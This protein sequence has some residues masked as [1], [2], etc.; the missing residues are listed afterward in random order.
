MPRQ[1]ASCIPP[2]CRTMQDNV[3][4]K[5]MLSCLLLSCLLHPPWMKDNVGCKTDLS[6]LLQSCILYPLLYDRRLHE[7]FYSYYRGSCRSPFISLIRPRFFWIR[8]GFLAY[9]NRMRAAQS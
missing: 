3:G 2:G 5:K 9:K 6:W 1:W 4:C 8:E 7:N